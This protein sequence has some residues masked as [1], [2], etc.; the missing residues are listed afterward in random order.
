MGTA[1]ELLFVICAAVAVVTAV[2]TVYFA[3]PLRAAMALLLHV[4]SLAG[5]YLTLSAHFL[6]AIQVLVYAGAVVV[7]FVFTIMLIGPEAQPDDDPESRARG[8]RMV[9]VRILS[10]V[11]VAFGIL[12]LGFVLGGRDLPF[13]NLAHCAPAAGAECG[14]FGGVKAV[15][16]LLFK[17]TVVPFEIVSILLTVAIVGAVAVARGRNPQEVKAYQALRAAKEAEVKA[18]EAELSQDKPL[19][20]QTA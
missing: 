11:L 18:R 16:M 1:G 13:Q 3:H 14:Q 9:G 15:G 2:M 5:V 4:V 20:G 19:E 8:V 10:A 6:A 12:A 7:L 17:E